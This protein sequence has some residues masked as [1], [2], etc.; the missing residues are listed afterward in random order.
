MQERDPS[1]PRRLEI[2]LMP[3]EYRYVEQVAERLGVTINEAVAILVETIVK[4]HVLSS[5]SVKIGSQAAPAPLLDHASK[6]ASVAA[7]VTRVQRKTWRSLL[8]AIASLLGLLL[9][10][11]YILWKTYG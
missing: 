4:V 6:H 9:A 5:I 11:I 3:D 10:L 8:P 7:S 2:E 1:Q